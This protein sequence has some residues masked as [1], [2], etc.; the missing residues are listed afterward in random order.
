LVSALLVL[1][2]LLVVV[3]TVAWHIYNNQFIKFDNN[4]NIK[5]P[6]KS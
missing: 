2:V 4:Y 5:K 6:N 1:L 3:C